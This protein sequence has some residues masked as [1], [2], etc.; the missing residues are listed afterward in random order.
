AG[1]KSLWNAITASAF[2]LMIL[3]AGIS[4]IGG[5]IV[6][7]TIMFVSVVER[8][9]EIGLRMALGARRRDIKRQFLL[10][11]ALLA[12]GGGVVGVILGALAAMAVNQIFPAR[13]RLVFILIGIG[14][15]T[16]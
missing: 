11:S 1:F 5:A 15:A 10:E 2:G 7:A 14:T 9:K 13:V 6:I 4:L 12:T 3:I 8:T 16:L